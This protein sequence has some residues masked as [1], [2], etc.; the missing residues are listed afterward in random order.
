LPPITANLELAAAAEAHNATESIHEID[1]DALH[2]ES[3]IHLARVVNVSCTIVHWQVGNALSA[4]FKRKA[5]DIDDALKV[6]DAYGAIPIRLM[7]GSLRQA[8]ELS[9][10]LNIYA[11]DAY[12]I[13]C[14]I[15]QKAPILTR[16]GGDVPP[17]L[18]S[19]WV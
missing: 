15:N 10:K 8:V 14:A 13:A 2:A 12:V 11:Y 5:I 18:S 3:W 4:M 17:V 19:V 7:E 9:A 16:D 6:L 1:A